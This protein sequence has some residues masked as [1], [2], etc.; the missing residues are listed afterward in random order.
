MTR[1]DGIVAGCFGALWVLSVAVGAN[2]VWQ[3]QTTAGAPGVPA[4]RWPVGS[5]LPPPADRPTLLLIAHPQCPCTRASIG[6]LDRLM[7]RLRDRVS[8]QVLVFKPREFPEGWERTE[9]WSAAERIPGVTVRVD[10]DGLEAARFGAATSG[11]VLLYDSGGRR[12]F[13]GGITTAR[14]H[15]GEGLGQARIAAIVDGRLKEEFT[16]RVFG[17][18]LAGSAQA[19]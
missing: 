14:G 13:S 17:C 19:D 3:Y 5:V 16:T 4:A 2:A 1:R 6:E 15:R 18:A 11:Q 9:V 8:A 7:T 12:R 10:V